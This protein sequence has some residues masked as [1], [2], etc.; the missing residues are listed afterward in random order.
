MSL[1]N[2]YC[3]NSVYF[4]FIFNTGIHRIALINDEV[5]LSKLS[6]FYNL[7]FYEYR[8]ELRINSYWSV[9]ECP[10]GLSEVHKLF[11]HM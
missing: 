1:V 3:I 10:D 2:D 11:L 9:C 7:F 5:T 6:C 8:V 4:G